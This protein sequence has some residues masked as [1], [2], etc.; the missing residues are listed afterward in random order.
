[1]PKNK[2]RSLDEWQEFEN[3]KEYNVRLGLYE[4]VAKNE[5]FYRGEQWK[6]VGANNLPTPVFNLFKRIIDYYVSNVMSDATVLHYS[7]IRQGDN[8]A[9]DEMAGV[10]SG[11]AKARW[12]RLKMDS[13]LSN[14]L[15]DAALCGDAVAYTYWDPT[16]KTGQPFRGDF[17]TRL[18]ENTNVFFGNPNVHDVQAQPY[19]MISG[20]EMVDEVK[21]QAKANGRDAHV[22]GLIDSD[23]DI[24]TQS[25]DR[26]SIELSG[27]KC[28]T[29]IKLWRNERGTISFKKMV[30]DAVIIDEVDTGLHLYPICYFNWTRSKN[31]WLG[32][33]VGT[34]LIDNQIFVNKAFAMAMKHMMDTAFSKIVY[35]STVIDEWSNKVG[36]A[37]AVNGP[38]ENV[39]KAIGTGSMQSG[40]LELINLAISYTKDMLGATDA[41]LGNVDPKNTSAI[42]AVQQASAM[43]LQ[44]VKRQLYQFI[45]DLGLIWLD[46]ML[47]YYGEKRLVPS[48]DG[49]WVEFSP[50]RFKGSVWACS[51]DVGNSGYYSEIT[52]LNTLD[53][54]L[55]MGQITLKQYLERIPNNIIPKKQEL[56]DEITASIEKDE[57][58]RI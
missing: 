16:I 53:T 11:I 25:G 4:T 34:S 44:N 49:D 30:K 12:E 24:F 58:E 3:G 45:E 43:P 56:I 18:V 10:L 15:L 14:A 38:I 17:V 40:M 36:E 31:C 50:K 2:R 35:D 6:G 54:L 48:L 57:E 32:E 41:A 33:A 28:V 42:I 29:L 9:S 55:S 5:R 19:I 8:K 13:L 7:S 20:R 22:I 27:T 1:M 46:F 39:A 23:S 47:C 21:K 51:V 37:I 52:S 26:G